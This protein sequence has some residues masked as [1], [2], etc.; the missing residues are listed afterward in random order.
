MTIQ[1]PDELARDLE[2]IATAQHKSVEQVAVERI[3]STLHREK[4]PQQLLQSLRKMGRPSGE[5]V[6]ELEAA[7][8]Q[9]KLPVRELG[10][11]DI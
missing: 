7:I 3:Q 2:S 6:D 1:I 9:E 4:S 5:A 8:A 10:E 11:F